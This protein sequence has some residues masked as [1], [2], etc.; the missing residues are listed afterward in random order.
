M[1]DLSLLQ[2]FLTEAGEHLAAMESGLLQL[3]TD[4]DNRD[5][6]DD[7]FRSVHTIKGAAGFVGLEKVSE[8]ALKL[9]NLLDL[10]RQGQKQINRD[11]IDTLIEAKDRIALL[12]EELERSQAE[13]TLIDDLATRI[14]QL[15]E[16]P[17]EYAAQEVPGEE[18]EDLSG[19]AVEEGAGEDIEDLSEEYAEESTGED[20]EEP[21]YEEQAE[22]ASGED[23]EI[24]EAATP[25]T[26]E[27]EDYEEEYDKELFAIFMQQLKENISFVRSQTD[28][29]DVSGNQSEVLERCADSIESL[30][31]SANYM[32]YPK[33]T[34]L[35]INWCA[36]IA[37]AQK[38][39]SAGNEVPLDFMNAYIDKIV[40]I[41][42][43]AGELEAE[44]EAAAAAVE[45]EEAL[46]A[47]KELETATEEPQEALTDIEELEAAAEEPEEALTAVEKLDAAAE[48]PEEAL[49][50][51]EELEAPPV[52]EEESLA[53]GEKLEAV[54]EDQAEALT[55]GEEPEA[56]DLTAESKIDLSLLPDFLTEAGEH[57]VE[58]ESGLLQLE[59]DPE[60]RDILDDVFRSIHTIKGAAEFVGLEKVSELSHKL[61][62]L[63]AQLRQG[64]KQVN[65]DMIDTLI[66]AKDRIALL[67]EELER[68]QAE[69]TPVDDLAARITQLTEGP[70]EYTAE[71]VSEEA[72]QGQEAIEVADREIEPET[73]EGETYEEEYDKELFGIFIQQLKE[74]IS[75]LISQANE[76]SASDNKIEV[77]ERCA[78]SIES[79]KASANYMGY[80]KL[81][82][83]YKNWL[84]EIDGAKEELSAGNEVSCD[85]M[86][87]YIDKIVNIFP[88]AQEV[89][90]I[91]DREEALAAGEEFEAAPPE[92]EEAPAS[93]E[94]AEPVEEEV[95]TA[96]EELEAAPQAADLIPADNK[97]F[98]TLGQAFDASM[99][100]ASETESE[101]LAGV[102]EEM[103]SAGGQ[104]APAEPPPLEPAH[105]AEPARAE[106]KQTDVAADE[107]P[108]PDVPA[109]A[110]PADEAAKSEVDRQEGIPE[111][112]IDR[113][114]MDRRITD[115]R[116]SDSPG[117]RI[118][119]QSVRV[120]ADKI[121][122]LMNQ[123]G[124]LVV[125]RA[126]FSQLS[127]E[128]RGLQQHLKEEIGLD[129]KGLKPVRAL[130]FRLG[131]AI[132]S[133]G[134]VAN[135]LQE[136]VMKVRMLP[137]SQLFN[138]Y[139]R[140]VRDLT[141]N[142]DK[143][144]RLEIRGQET[145]LD[146]MIIEEISD[147]LIHTIR[148][149]VDHGI[150]SVK[151]RKRVGKPQSGT[152]ILEAYHESNHIVIEIT[153]DGRGI[154]PGRIKA[155]ALEKGF[156]SKEE[157]DRMSPKELARIIMVPGF[158]TAEK[159]SHTSGR[160]VGMDVVKKN[161]EKLNGTMEIDSTP[162]VK[163][164]M[165]I[166][167][168]LTLAIIQALMVRVGMDL[169]TIPLSAVEET[170]R[171]SET[172]TSLMEGVEVIHMRDR[173]MPIFRLSYM[174][175][176]TPD[177]QDDD[178]AYVVIVSTGMQQIGLVVDELVGQEEVVIKPLV[179]YLQENSGFSGAT[180]IRDGKI[181]LILD[182]YE[183]VNMT[184][185]MQTKRH[186]D[187][188]LDRLSAAKESGTY[189]TPA[190]A[191]A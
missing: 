120:S 151:E 77:L 176:I 91:E 54:S 133:L 184:I 71:G 8:L 166:K 124:E 113:R 22:D 28:E 65:R 79:L 10:L 169:F 98:E 16:G 7:I 69:E 168:P 3:E 165:R 178:R 6:L 123:V 127:N 4:S 103:L 80:R 36:E 99:D 105:Q 21:V 68:S 15:T 142:T 84:A 111:N 170:L 9:E 92:E 44:V 167:I 138:R 40:E 117:D 188:A 25:E 61:E 171:I 97:L 143:Q 114:K 149:A 174:F 158:S 63:L 57:L 155:K 39:L 95:L 14:T 43:Q 62:N 32:D 157:L 131:E 156:F 160:G 87:A 116:K 81:T 55:L 102:I 41:F 51:G 191:N 136:G 145:E 153:D 2:D 5:I 162:G 109:F 112:R 146:K 53:A 185:G 183:L 11:I 110:T 50:A 144:V 180:I 159:V 129:Q 152:L 20:V 49:T 48:E 12:V 42:P 119:K 72:A 132:V 115:R 107:P 26:V 83:R 58:M 137:I 101:P 86:K 182:V 90:A 29:L 88:Q 104:T 78:D 30:K 73:V 154:D 74:N 27:D 139:P 59:T 173:T 135:D 18:T 140:L 17:G 67:V 52:E 130:S 35:Y 93:V 33:L 161:I 126:F 1:I 186:K 147:P 181:S 94:E 100:Q 118:V 106:L 189:Q 108:S 60:S 190:P 75:F 66:E 38:E 175:G 148:N 19:E 85:F 37:E 150:E 46:T 128:M 125:S 76:L 64:Q 96:I 45:P 70:A 187:L 163:T 23:V 179:D 121:D 164:Q 89:A 141:H 134:R 34:G 31:S 177:Q 56:S 82:G 24:E 13:E 172:E 47:G 122:S